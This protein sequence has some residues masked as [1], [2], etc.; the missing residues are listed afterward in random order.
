MCAGNSL[1]VRHSFTA[2]TLRTYAAS[3]KYANKSADADRIA[4]GHQVKVQ[5][6]GELLWCSFA[7]IVAVIRVA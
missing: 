5:S 4:S 6:F 1:A 3:Q 2:T 7:L